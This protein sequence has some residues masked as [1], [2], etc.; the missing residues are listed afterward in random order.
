MNNLLKKLQEYA[1]A[2]LRYGMAAVILWF[3]SQ[4]FLH[5]DVWIAYIPDNV[6]TMT[7]MS[8][9]KLVYI[10]A[11]F[12]L[13]FGLLMTFGFMTRISAFLLTIHLLDIMWVVGYGEIGVRDFGLAVA[14]FAVFMNGPDNLCLDGKSENDKIKT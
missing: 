4:Q 11:V 1:P 9:V 8:A 5:T 12:E 10:N 13:V 3:S 7:G 6:V 14:T 2:V